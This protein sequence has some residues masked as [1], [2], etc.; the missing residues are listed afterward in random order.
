MF[1]HSVFSAYPGISIN[2]DW[3]TCESILETASVANK[4]YYLYIYCQI[5]NIFP[6]I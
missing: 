1:T 3:A 2:H 6:Q 4:I 5:R